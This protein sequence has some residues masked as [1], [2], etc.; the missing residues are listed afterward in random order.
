[1]MPAGLSG[2][3]EAHAFLGNSDN[4]F[5]CSEGKAESH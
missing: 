5:F 3:E 2:S 4:V 1:M